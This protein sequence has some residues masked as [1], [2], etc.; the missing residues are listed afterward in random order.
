MKNVQKYERHILN[1]GVGYIY[2]LY[3]LYVNCFVGV[4]IFF[5]GVPQENETNTKYHLEENV[6]LLKILHNNLKKKGR[7]WWVYIEKVFTK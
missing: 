2:Y 6:L 1:I 7:W 4:Y 5:L 3:I